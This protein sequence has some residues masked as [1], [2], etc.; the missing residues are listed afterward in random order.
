MNFKKFYIIFFLILS[1]C[2]VYN[3][4]TVS[5]E[6][7]NKKSGKVIFKKPSTALTKIV[8][9]ENEKHIIGILDIMVWNP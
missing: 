4:D 5:P 8:I 2:T 9:S 3:Q 7:L 1:N 6:L